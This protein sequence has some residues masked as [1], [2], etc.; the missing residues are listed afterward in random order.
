M[1]LKK[2]INKKKRIKTNQ[3]AIK[4]MM[5]KLYAKTKWNDTCILWQGEKREKEGGEDKS[6]S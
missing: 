5:I 1:K 2:E 3:I 4:K 6:L